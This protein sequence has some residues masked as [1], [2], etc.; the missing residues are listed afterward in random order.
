MDD[1]GGVRD[2]GSAY[3]F[4]TNGTLVATLANPDPEL[5]DHFGYSV[6]GIGSDRA[7][8]G[9]YRDDPGGVQDAG[10][11][12]LFD[13]NG[14]LLATLPN[15]EPGFRDF[16]GQSVSGVGVDK[17]LVG[18]PL[19]SPGV[20]VLRAARIFSTQ[21]EPCWPSCRTPSRSS[22]RIPIRTKPTS[23]ATP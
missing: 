9:A 3:L 10:S 17:L 2:A 18:A 6:V 1:P 5:H 7:L 16:F 12:Y 11:A 14:T 20:W 22:M 13:T 4:D 19:D 15:P 8:V 23:S 21:T